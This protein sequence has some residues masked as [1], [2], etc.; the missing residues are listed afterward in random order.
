[1]RAR[2]I[3]AGFA[4]GV[5]A[6]AAA[7]CGGMSSVGS[8]SLGGA[9]T[10]APSDSVAFVAFDSNL[11]SGQWNA[12]D[13]LLQKFPAHDDLLTKL[14]TAFEQRSK[15]SWSNDVK[16][17]LGSELDLIALPGP[18]PGKDAQ[19]VGLTQGSDKPKLDALLHKVDTGISTVQIGDW[20][21]FSRSQAALD[22]VQNASTKLADNNT[23][24]AAIAKL[25]SDALVRA[26]ANG[27][28]AQQL[29]TSL[30]TQ[31]AADSSVPFAWASA[32]VVASGDGVRINGYSHDSA[33]SG[34]TTAPAAPYASSLVDEIP[35]GALL[36][37]D[38]PVTPGELQ[39]SPGSLPKPLQT[40]LG[41]SPAILPD[42]DQLLG[43][44]TALYVRPG[45]PIPEVTLVTQPV[46][47]PKA[48]TALDD[49]LKTIRA[50]AAGAKGGIDL[51]SVPVFHKA[52]GGRLIV[53]TSQQGIA[54]F[55]SGGTK[56]SADPSFSGAQHASAMPAQ[57]TG[58]LYVNLAA[59]LPL[60]QAVGPMLG[61]NVPTSGQADLSALKTLTAFGGR[62]GQDSTFSVFVEVR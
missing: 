40:L 55:T 6:L 52:V 17:A 38:F 3:F 7:G 41:N 31:S 62:A 25:A 48:E 15:L 56:L 37:A 46:D 12:V 47:V 35:S 50:A 20:T 34:S 44:E 9:A 29:L 53:S 1:M 36:V 11:S 58:F 49:L 51:S 39:V 28:E 2:S 5:A 22:A 27:A 30:G 24:Q 43:G 14:R 61:L 4:A 18:G 10:I 59:A 8:T 16:P 57:T 21:A 23:Y 19:L 32:D 13:G 54:D 60:V 45:L 26:Y 42:L 33:T